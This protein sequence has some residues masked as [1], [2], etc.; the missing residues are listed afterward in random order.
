MANGHDFESKHHSAD[1][2]CAVTPCPAC[3]ARDCGF[4]DPE[5]DL[6]RLDAMSE[7]WRLNAAVIAQAMD[8]VSLYRQSDKVQSRNEDR[9]L[10]CHIVH[11]DAHLVEAVLIREQGR[12]KRAT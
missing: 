8:L 7:P 3:G 1:R 10:R 12:A 9:R 6:G 4:F 11:A 2:K 5:D